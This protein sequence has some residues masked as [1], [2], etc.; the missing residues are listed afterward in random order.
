[1][2]HPIFIASPSEVFVFS[3]RGCPNGDRCGFC[4]FAHPEITSMPRP[5]RASR[6][7]IKEKVLRCFAA[8]SFEEM[9]RALQEEARKHVYA[10]RRKWRKNGMVP[11]NSK[12][13]KYLKPP[14]TKKNKNFLSV[15]EI[16]AAQLGAWTI[17]GCPKNMPAALSGSNTRMV[18]EPLVKT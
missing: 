17:I 1:M 18:L 14:S 13:L 9:H 11:L 16:G 3:D 10:T 5:W 8:A 7:R 15:C 6:Q 2:G 12:V 4:H